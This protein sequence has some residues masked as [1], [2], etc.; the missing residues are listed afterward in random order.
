M[1]EKSRRIKSST[2]TVDKVYK[3]ILFNSLLFIKILINLNF[4]LFSYNKT[5][6]NGYYPITFCSF[7]DIFFIFW[8]AQISQV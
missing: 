5:I 1:K 6:N 8:A 3:N 7:N 2:Q 4:Y